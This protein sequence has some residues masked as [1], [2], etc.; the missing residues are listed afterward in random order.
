MA[1]SS[2]NREPAASRAAH[3]CSI[4]AARRPWE[5]MLWTERAQQLAFEWREM[6]RWSGE[7]EPERKEERKSEKERRGGR[8]RNKDRGERE[9]DE[10]RVSRDRARCNARA[11][12]HKQRRASQSAPAKV[13]RVM[14]RCPLCRTNSATPKPVTRS[15][16]GARGGSA[17]ENET[18]ITRREREDDEVRLG[19]AVRQ[20]S[21]WPSEF[22]E[23]AV[24]CNVPSGIM[25]SSDGLKN[26]PIAAHLL[27]ML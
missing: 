18:A 1:E 27:S 13:T 7:R 15:D 5:E 2:R 20:A 12:L 9:K 17:G 11:A 25:T 24:L 21:P 10:T 6:T 23:T 16:S 22:T 26:D 4:N 3:A 19:R 14:S 8:E